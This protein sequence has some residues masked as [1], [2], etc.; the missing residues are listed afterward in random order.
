MTVTVAYLFKG[1]FE[2]L[3]CRYQVPLL[4]VYVAESIPRFLLGWQ[5]LD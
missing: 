5:Q 4:P 3:L 2:A 1:S